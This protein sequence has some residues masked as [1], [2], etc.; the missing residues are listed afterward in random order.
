MDGEQVLLYDTTLRDGTQ[1]EG[2]SLSVGD[3]LKITGLLDQLGMAYIEGGWPG[4]NPKDDEYF[5]RVHDVPLACSRIAAFG[6]TCRV[7]AS[8]DGDAGFCALLAANTAVVTLVGKSWTMHVR[9][10]LRTTLDENLR[11]IRESNASLKAHGREAIYDAEHFFDGYL[12]DSAYALDCLRAAVDGGADVLVLCDTRGGTMPWDIERIVREVR[13]A[14]PGVRLGIHVHNDAGT[15]SANSLTAIRAGVTHLQGTINGY[16]ERSG[17][18]NLC[19]IIP[20]LELKMG[21]RALPPGRMEQ[22]TRTSR[23]VAAIVN[24]P[25]R[26]DAPYVGQSAFAH[27]AGIHASAMRRN[28]A[29]YQHID[30]ALVGNA[31]RILFSELS[32]KASLLSK[33][34]E[35]GIAVDQAADLQGVLDTTKELEHSGF[36]FEGAEASVELLLK[37]RSPNYVPPFEMVDFMVVVEHRERRGVFSEATIKVRV[38]DTEMHTAAQG[39]GPV[40]ALYNALRKA[41]VP[42]YPEMDR[43]HLVDYKVWILDSDKATGA[44]TRVLI[45]TQN[46][47]SCWTTVGASAN[48]IQASWLALA[49]AVEYGLT[50]GKSKH[51]ESGDN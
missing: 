40:D 21:I 15:A 4:A 41:L 26:Q 1:G 9:E 48:I 12:A 14:L 20:N 28:P 32:G 44:T 38:G 10:I 19:T 50:V 30:P 24:Q 46:T 45:D 13:Q 2:I 27:K 8:P 47:T 33:A 18:A 42:L 7:G 16:G 25:L 6:S 37:R 3:K 49:D 11:I 22:L 43:F 5:Q 29:S 31:S 51:K 39:N 34:E 17:N 35:M 23:M 36:S